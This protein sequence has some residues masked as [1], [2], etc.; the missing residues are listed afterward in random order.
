[1]ECQTNETLTEH[2]YCI[3]S[4][5]GNVN[6]V[7]INYTLLVVNLIVAILSISRSS[8]SPREEEQGRPHGYTRLSS[9]R[10]EDDNGT[11]TK[12]RIFAIVSLVVVIM[13]QIVLCLLVQCS[14]ISIIWCAI[15]GWILM[16]QYYTRDDGYDIGSTN[17]TTTTISTTRQLISCRNLH[18]MSI[19]VIDLVAIV[20][21]FIVLE[22]I[23]TVAHVLAIVVL[24]IPLYT[25]YRRIH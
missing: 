5:E 17:G 9:E 20:Y 2:L 16:D 4:Y 25:I 19:L 14:G 18:Q 1:M 11:L 23:T 10:H 7:I 21:Y 13:F 8:R 6:D 15:G 12:Q 24:G 3:L 22:P